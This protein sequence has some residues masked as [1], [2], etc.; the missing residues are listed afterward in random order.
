MDVTGFPLMSYDST[1][2]AQDS[3]FATLVF[4]DE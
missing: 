4:E 2:S 3:G 1:P